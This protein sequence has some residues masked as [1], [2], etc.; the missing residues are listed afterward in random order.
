MQCY[1]ELLP[2]SGVTHAISLP[3]LSATSNNLIVA[4]T[5]ILQVF[6]LVNVAYG[7]SALPNA[8]DKG[9]VERQQY[10][11]LILVAE[12]DLSGTITGLGRVKILDSRSGGE[13]LLVATRN[14]KLSLVEW[15]HERHGISTI[16]IHYY[17]REDVHSSPWTPDLK[18]CPSLLAVDPSS[19][20]AILNFGIHSVAILPFHQ[21]GDDLVMDEFD[22]DLD[23][24]PEGASNIPAQIAVENDTTMYK[25]PYASS[26]VLPLTALDPALVHPIHLA[27]LY[28]Y[29]EPTFGI[30][31]S[32]LTTSSALLR[33]RK[34]IVSYSVFTLDIQQRASTTLITVSRLPSDLWKVVPLPPPIG[35][36]LLIGSNELIHV[37]QAGKTNAVGINEFA[38]QASAFSM[39]DQSDL[40]L[41]LEGCVVEQLGT[42]SGDIL[43][44]LA[45]GKMAI[46]RLKVDGRSVSGISAQLVSEK[47]GG[48]ILKARPSCSASLGRGKVFFGSEETDS[49]LIGW[50]RPSQLMRKPKVESADDVFGD[51]S[52]TEDDEDDIYEDD[53]YST[54]VNQ[55]TLSKTTSQTNGLNKDDFVFRSHDRL[56]NLGPMSDVTLGR[57]P[58]SHDKNRKQSSSRTSADLEL[59]VTQGKGNA[60]GLAVLQRELDPY[61]I[62]SMK[63]DNVD[64]VW[65]IQVGAPDSTNTRTSSRNYDKYLVFSKSTE[66]GKE[67]SVVYSV[68]GSGIEEMKAP[69]FN[70]N[71]DSTVDI[72]TLAGGTR[73]VQVLK[74]EVRSYDTN[75]E[76]AQ[77][78][79]IWDEDT[80]DELSVVSAS[81]A[82]PYVLIVRDDQ[83]LLL[84]QADKSGD[85][86]EVNI[87][88]I[89]SSHRWLSGCLYLDKYHTFVP[90]KGQDQ[91]LSDNILLVLL[92]AD[93][94]LFIFSLPTLTE[95]LC[96]VDGVDLLP[97]ILSCEPPPKR[98]TYRETLSEVLIAD[99]GDSIS[100]QPYIIPYHPKTS[101]DKQE[102]RFV[103]I[104]DHFLP[105]FDPS[106]KAYMPRSKFLRAYSDI[107]GYKTVFMSGSNPCFVMKS[108]TSSPHVLRL[109]GEAVSSLSSFHIPACE[110]G[111][112]YV[113]ASV[114]VPKQY[115]VPW[116]KLILVIQNMVRMC[117]LPGNTRF[118]N[119]W[120]TRKVHV[121]D[122]ID[123]VEYFAH[124][125]I[126]ALGSSHKVDFKLPEDDE[127]HPE[128]RSEVISFMPQL[129]RGCIKLLSPRTWSVVDSY[130]LGDAERVM[131]MKTINMEISE[132]THEMKDMLVVGT[133]TVRGEDIT[134]R[135]SIYVFEII[136]VAPDPDR[137]ETNRK[138]KIFAKDDVKGAVTAVSGIGGQGFL[139]M[140]QGQKCMVRGLK[141]DG[142]L[143]PVAFMDMQCYVKVLKE[144]QGT[145]LCIMGDALKGIWFAGYSEEPYRLTLFG[146]DNEYLQVI[147]AD[148]L[149]DGKRL[150]IL[151]ADDDC[152]IHVLEYDP[153]DP[154]SS[155]GD[156]LLHRSSFHMGHFTS[157]MTLLPQHSSSPS[158]DDPGEDD[159]DV[160]YVPKSYQVLVTS[161]EGS[162]GVVTPLTEDSYR[163]LSA[164]QSQLVTSME[165][166]CGLNPKAYRAVE[167]DGFGGRGIVDGN[168]LLRWLDMGVQRKAEIAGRVGAD[169][170]S[171]RVDLEKISG[172]LD[173]L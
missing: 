77:I 5:S 165:H 97:L 102:L 11:K 95:P 163:R 18:L 135:G 86:D 111:F 105:R 55:T 28:E 143:L 63:M 131:C 13:A 51:H 49:L 138:L 81:F 45:D 123:C 144:L 140:A 150:Y 16:S 47:A 6:S 35:G 110:K 32:H 151:V 133:A 130:E 58:G 115:F 30:L 15:D 88:G 79:P 67:Q 136:E 120:V 57:P 172:G 90:T 41:R 168:L 4:K 20:C 141:E 156:R 89:L 17:E 112:A 34:D 25:T 85:L 73:V 132:I 121:G 117:R 92:R 22:G 1:T 99:L 154:T 2:P 106:P 173:F 160:D 139:I 167:S 125:E 76:L 113:D 157:T 137:P 128:W 122:Q 43:L 14:A 126:Y 71:E 9:R 142:S 42:D 68:G 70:P 149:P 87:D 107:C 109:R 54:P 62:D 75:L 69:E 170:E 59:V 46:L 148:F 116:N 93:H 129:E 72:G 40:G 74:S 152:T 169:I 101:L 60:G 155:K 38:R 118:D 8:D 64:G 3:F 104:I 56:W 83:S 10:T 53:L 124:S 96:S 103:K 66:P 52:E 31:Y 134:P 164:L 65:S 7:T 146:K 27:F 39:V 114:C 108:S 78:Y 82:E 23:E 24:K 33:D 162:I 48:S 159:M 98:V 161:Q 21:T 166:P 127:I 26:F 29:R 91:P 80:S 84:L 50:S 37:D 94:T 153:E 12:Y 171:I 44:V 158:A 145:G 100:R 19:R 36:A 61:V 119:S 147:A